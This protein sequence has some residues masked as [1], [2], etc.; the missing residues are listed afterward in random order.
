MPNRQ[1]GSTG[2]RVGA[3]RRVRHFCMVPGCQNEGYYTLNLRMRRPD[4][5]AVFAPSTGA[6]FCDDHVIGANIEINYIPNTSGKVRVETTAQKDTSSRKRSEVE[7]RE[8]EIVLP[9]N[10]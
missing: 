9:R 3:G 2:R 4:T 10:E 8:M 1:R 7:A 5:S 6:Y